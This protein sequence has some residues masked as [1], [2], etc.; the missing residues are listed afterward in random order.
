MKVL[1]ACR[2][3]YVDVEYLRVK[4]GQSAGSR[5]RSPYVDMPASSSSSTVHPSDLRYAW[6]NLPASTKFLYRGRRDYEQSVHGIKR[7]RG[8]VGK[9]VSKSAITRSSVYTDIL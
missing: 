1:A 5:T 2:N 8:G 3:P 7:D 9:W 4:M 6:D